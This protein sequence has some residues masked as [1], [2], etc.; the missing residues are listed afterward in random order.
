MIRVRE[1]ALLSVPCKKELNDWLK[2]KADNPWIFQG[3]CFPLSNMSHESW[4]T[5]RFNTNVAE[6]AHAMSQR[7][8]KHLSLVGAIMAGERLDAQFLESRR[9][10]M[11]FGVSTNY[12]NKSVTE[13]TQKNMARNNKRAAKRRE[14]RKKVDE[15]VEKTVAA[16]TDLLMDRLM[17]SG[18]LER[19]LGGRN[20]A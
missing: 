15:S 6:A 20:K 13:R 12:G 9:T 4:F 5:T 19:V 2:H 18:D 16:A 17:N 11:Q 1:H 14:E 10:A 7:S 3:L 8:G